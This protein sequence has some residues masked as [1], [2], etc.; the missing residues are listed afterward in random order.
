[1]TSMTAYSK[2][3]IPVDSPLAYVTF[4]YTSDKSSYFLTAVGEF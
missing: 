4:G 3:K 2:L 1:M